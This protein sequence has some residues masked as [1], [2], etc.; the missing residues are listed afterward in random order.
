MLLGGAFFGQ[1]NGPPPVVRTPSYWNSGGRGDRTASI[2]VTTTASLGA[3]T[4]N[5]IVD[6]DFT[7]NSTGACWFTNGQSSKEIKFDF[8]SG[9][10]KIVNGFRW[11][12]NQPNT[13]GTWVLEASNDDSSYTQI[14]SSFTLGGICSTYTFSNGN[15][16]RYYKL[17]QTAG[18]TSS[19]PWLVE[20]EFSL[21]DTTTDGARDALEAGDRTGTIAVTTTASL[22]FS[23]SISNLVDGAFGASGTDSAA[24]TGSESTREIK[25][26]LGSGKIITE[27]LWVQTA[28]SLTSATG[29]HGTWVWEG[30]ND[31]SSYTTIGA[32]FTLGGTQLLDIAR[33]NSTAYRYYKLRQTAGTTNSGPWLVE[34]E[35]KIS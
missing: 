29:S 12:Q 22:G 23:S 20:V 9:I 1:N 14:G 17:R 7:V 34:I 30:S 31:D 10:T 32:S 4:I 28:G 13:H 8:G 5:N 26:D 6:G 3:G 2:A 25:F 16:Y 21:A 19:S 15:G 35:F 27:F 18:T 33:A 24:F 11:V